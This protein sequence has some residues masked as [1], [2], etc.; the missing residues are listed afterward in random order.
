MTSI[1]GTSLELGYCWVVIKLQRAADNL[2]VSTGLS[3]LLVTILFC[4]EQ[5]L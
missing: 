5:S 3:I 1:H 2:S 4:A